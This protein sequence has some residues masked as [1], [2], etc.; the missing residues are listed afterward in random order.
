MPAAGAAKRK[1]VELGDGVV[2][3]LATRMS[4]L[5]PHSWTWTLHACC[6]ATSDVAHEARHAHVTPNLSALDVATGPSAISTA[7]L[8]TLFDSI[9]VATVYLR[10]ACTD[11]A[12]LLLLL[13]MLHGC[14]LLYQE[15]CTY[16]SVLYIHSPDGIWFFSFILLPPHIN[17][18]RPCFTSSSRPPS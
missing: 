11:V 6:S 12:Q 16:R 10:L 2:R 5:V 18:T 14:C 15:P 17:T 9:P 8:R 13:L 4:E 1:L 3:E 7:A